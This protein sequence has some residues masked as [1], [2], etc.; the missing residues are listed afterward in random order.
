MAYSISTRELLHVLNARSDV[1]LVDIV[2]E[3]EFLREHIHGAISLPSGE[4]ILKAA[5]VLDRND[6][7]VVY[8]REK[9]RDQSEAAVEALQ[10]LGFKHIVTYTDGF[11][12]YK[13]ANLP[14]ETWL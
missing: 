9:T 7:I 2:S 10:S 12:G 11:D 5:L 1:K 13:K 6:L 3:D 14:S 8:G 4:I